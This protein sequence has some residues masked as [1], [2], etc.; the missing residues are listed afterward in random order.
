MMIT[1]EMLRA[2]LE[3]RE[4]W[5]FRATDRRKL[6]NGKIVRFVNW[7]WRRP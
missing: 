1:T 5:H 7:N 4:P 2:V 3:A 6:S